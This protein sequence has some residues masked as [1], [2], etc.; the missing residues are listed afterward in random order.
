[1]GRRLG[2]MRPRRASPR[3]DQRPA[4]ARR[5][6]ISTSAILGLTERA[7]PAPTFSFSRGPWLDAGSQQGCT[8][9]RRR[10]RRTGAS[11]FA[12]GP[13]GRIWTGAGRRTARAAAC[14]S[15]TRPRSAT[16]PPVV[17]VR[18]RPATAIELQEPGG[19]WP[20]GATPMEPPR[21]AEAL[22]AWS[23]GGPPG[24]LGRV[25]AGHHS[26]RPQRGLRAM[27]ARHMRDLCRQPP[28]GTSPSG[29]VP[30]VVVIEAEDLWHQAGTHHRL[31]SHR[32]RSDGSLSMAAFPPASGRSAPALGAVWQGRIEP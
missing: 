17:P 14:A 10:C 23:R 32:S 9:S 5:P 13:R 6:W 22:A 29:D 15:P 26:L 28:A 21:W 19:C 16:G 24:R 2:G 3:L 7:R 31:A 30:F 20:G 11:H 25:N 8:S 18:P 27:T 1:M 4:C 12:A